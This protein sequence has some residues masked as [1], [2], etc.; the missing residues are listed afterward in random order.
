MRWKGRRQS[1]NI[2]DRR[3]DTPAGMGGRRAGSAG[4]LRLLP[5]LMRTLG[6]KG[7][8]LVVAAF[9]A[10]TYFSGDGTG[11]LLGNGTAQ[12]TGG[13]EAPADSAEQELVEFVA[14]VLAETEATWQRQFAQQNR[15]YVQPQLVLYRGATRSAC[16]L[17]QA[18]M[19]PFYCPGDQ[20]IYLDLAFF[21]DLSRRHGAPGDFARAYVIAHEVGHHVQTLLG[22][23]EQVQRARQGMDEG[24]ANALSVRQELQA[25]CYAGLWGRDAD[26]RA[27]LLEAGDVEEALVAAGAIG[28]DRLQTQARGYV[29]PDSFTHGSSE[30]RVRWFRIGMTEGSLAACDTFRG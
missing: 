15:R 16:G 1:D 12:G 18:A 13:S 30:Q 11:S 5:L 21:D 2:E 28:D 14:V 19:G 22:I 20:K 27:D 8:V 24:S 7:T 26:Q 10:F 4:L 6:L 3:G 23:S 17:G 29:T 9:G 25:D